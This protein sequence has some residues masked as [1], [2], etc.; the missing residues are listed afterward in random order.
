MSEEFISCDQPI[1]QSTE[2]QS[3][4]TLIGLGALLLI[5]EL[6]TF[7]AHRHNRLYAL[8]FLLRFLGFLLFLRSGG[9]SSARDFREALS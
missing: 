1:R 2:K 3:L 8:V 7:G 6:Y 9:R 4:V 5:I